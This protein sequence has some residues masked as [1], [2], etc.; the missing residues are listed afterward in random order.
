MINKKIICIIPARLQSTRFPEKMLALLNGKPLIQYAWQAAVNTKIF[1]DVIIALDSEKTA[2][3]VKS[4]NANFLMTSQS[5]QSGTERLVEIMKSK[6]IS[7]DIW[8]NWQGDE[9]FINKEMIQ[10]LLQSINDDSDIWTLKKRITNQEEI[11]NPNFAKVVCD[12]AG[13][14]IYFSRSP[15]PFYRDEKDFEKQKY[16]KHVGIYAYTTKALQKIAQSKI[17]YL[18]DAEKLEQLTFIANNLKIKIHKT[19]QEVIGIDTPQD[20]KKAEIRLKK[21][22]KGSEVCI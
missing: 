2:T 3:V 13:S 4:F 22:E 19:D 15:I 16:Y 21:E 14:A 18:E 6:K 10:T 12:V 9:P 17:S 11:N 7:S 20:L 5:C 8:V 1:D